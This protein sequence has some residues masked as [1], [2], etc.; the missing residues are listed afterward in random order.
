MFNLV[1]LDG[2][3]CGPNGE[4]DWHNV[5]DEFNQFAIEQTSKFDTIIFGRI[6]YQ[7]FEDFWPKA[8]L[9][10]KTSKADL[11]IAN[12]IIEMNKIVFSRTLKQVEW[13]NT[14][15]FNRINPE[16]IVRLKKQAGRDIVIF[17][18]GTIVQTFVNLGLIDEYRVLI[19]PVILGRGKPLFKGINDKINL[20]LLKTRT[21]SNGNIL[22][23]Y[24]PK[25]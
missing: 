14:K 3:F 12:M 15:L 19:N 22:L 9:D 4:I 17:G 6:T 25:K 16:V 24:Q 1:T 23:V 2:L 21:F 8:A 13:K 20:K 11:K 7:L 10:P 5:D 18:S